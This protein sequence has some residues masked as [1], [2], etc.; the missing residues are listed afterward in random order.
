MDL[1]FKAPFT[2]DSERVLSAISE[3]VDSNPI[4]LSEKEKNVRI[5]ELGETEVKYIAR[6]WILSD[7][8]DEARWVIAAGVKKRFDEKGISQDII[9]SLK[10]RAV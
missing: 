9:E 8:I 1:Y 7:N 3:E 6:F 4:V 5:F 10:V 2:S